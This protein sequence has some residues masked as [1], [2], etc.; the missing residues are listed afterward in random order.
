MDGENVRGSGEGNEDQPLG[1]RSR[2]Q[3]TRHQSIFLDA[4]GIPDTGEVRLAQSILLHRKT[5]S[6]TMVTFQGRV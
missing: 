3:W 5:A 1:L 6:T 4:R 2:H